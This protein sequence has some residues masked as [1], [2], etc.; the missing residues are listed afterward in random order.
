MNINFDKNLSRLVFYLKNKKINFI[1]LFYDDQNIIHSSGVCL[2]KNNIDKFFYEFQ[3]DKYAVIGPTYTNKLY[4]GKQFYKKAL[5]LQIK[6]L[7][8]S[9]NIHEIFIST[10][11]IE[12]K[13]L[14][15]EYNDLKKF[16]SGVILSIFSKIFIYIIYNKFFK[17][18]V[19]FND[20]LILKLR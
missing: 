10:Q 14:S 3:K 20:N 18:R 8:E 13:L 9:Y 16:S 15:F 2:K 4:R 7:T 17:M 19:F 11:K 5:Q 12:K 6:N 1:F